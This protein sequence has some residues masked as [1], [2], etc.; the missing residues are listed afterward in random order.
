MNVFKSMTIGLS[1]LAL[2]SPGAY[3]FAQ[4][5]VGPN[6]EAATAHTSLELT[7]AEIDTLRQGGHTAALLW[8]ASGD[9]M[10]AVTS[11][12]QDEFERMG[13]SVVAAADAS[14]DASRQLSDVETAL[15]RNP[16]AII[17]LPVDPIASAA[18]FRPA[19]EAGT[20]L[21][22]LSNT[23][24]GYRH[25]NDYV[26]T[27]TDDVY[28]MGAAAALALAEALGDAGRIAMIYY[29]ADFYVTNLY[30]RGFRETL[31]S[32]F[33]GLEIVLERGFSDP[34]RVDEVTAAALTEYPDLDGIYVTWSEPAEGAVAAL[35]EAG[36]TTTKLV[37]LGI[38]EPLALDMIAGGN[39]VAIVVDRAYEL[40]RT[41]AIAT[42]YGLLGKP[43][44]AFITVGPA[45]TV[46]RENVAEGWTISLHQ[47][48][49]A[50]V[51][52]ALD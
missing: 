5:T 37:T 2:L 11:G 49:P 48:P 47:D 16:S 40:G 21:I 38:S 26:A 15:A 24:Q 13:V 50:S 10:Q 17:S 6:G 43:A 4:G 20:K 52:N 39:V 18:A 33:P 19:L 35:R 36:N 41:L 51:V 14:F 34:A 46:T 3:V 45:V 8:H 42:G 22:F 27:A 30:D 32:R 44:P 1:T 31:E 28:E 23:P 12:I 25:P 7:E 9:F 29:D